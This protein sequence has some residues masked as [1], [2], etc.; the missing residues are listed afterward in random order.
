MLP[1]ASLETREVTGFCGGDVGRRPFGG[2]L[3]A[4]GD[5]GRTQAP[6]FRCVRD[7]RRRQLETEAKELSAAGAAAEARVIIGDT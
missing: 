7:P 5:R 6:H 3:E 1:S 4:G 2:L